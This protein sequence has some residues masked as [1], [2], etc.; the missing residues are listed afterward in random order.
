ME[1]ESG[2]SPF[3][4]KG[5]LA[6]TKGLAKKLWEWLSGANLTSQW[7]SDTEKEVKKRKASKD[8]EKDTQFTHNPPAPLL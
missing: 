6:N 5:D 8:S 3:L 2:S 4:H 7:L 1:S